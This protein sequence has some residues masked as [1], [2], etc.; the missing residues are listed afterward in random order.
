MVVLLR[1]LEL[2]ILLF[3]LLF[4]LLDSLFLFINRVLRFL[5][6]SLLLLLVSLHRFL[7]VILHFAHVFDLKLLFLKDLF[8][9]LKLLIFVAQSVDL[10]LEFVGLLLFNHLDVATGDLADLRE[11]AVRKSITLKANVDQGGVLIKSLEHHSFDRLR[12]E[13]VRQ[14]DVTNSSIHLQ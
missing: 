4:L 7:Q 9:L 14:L 13:V 8:S 3:N 5:A 6:P 2:Q 10:S 12:E 11:A 1:F